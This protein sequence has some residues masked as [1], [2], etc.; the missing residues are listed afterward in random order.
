MPWRC[1]VGSERQ[2]SAEYKG[3]NQ[4]AEGVQ[5]GV[6]DGPL[7]GC[8]VS[9]AGWGSLGLLSQEAEWAGILRRS[10]LPQEDFRVMLLYGHDSPTQHPQ[11]WTSKHLLALPSHPVTVP[12]AAH[13]QQLLLGTGPFVPSPLQQLSSLS[14]A[15][16][17][18]EKKHGWLGGHPSPHLSGAGVQGCLFSPCILHH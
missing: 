18:T 5:C 17:A 12:S 15:D 7:R 8:F 16:L 3:T 13:N 6:Q 1:M 14:S 9:Q 4:E 10:P 11:S 2:S